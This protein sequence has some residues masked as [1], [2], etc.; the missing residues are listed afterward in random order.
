MIS[1]NGDS[2]SGDSGS[3]AA[4][5]V[6]APDLEELWGL[7][8]RLSRLDGGDLSEGE[9]VEEL[10]A[11]ERLKS[12]LAAAQARVTA[13]LAATRAD[14]EAGLPVAERCRGLGAEVGLARQESPVRG[15]QHLELAL[16]LVRE[17]P[18]TMAALT[19]GEISEWV[20][21]QVARET[22]VL[23]REDR[24]R[25]DAELDGQLVGAGVARI[26]RLARAIGYRLDPGSAVRR[27][28]GATADRR[29]GL[30]PAPDT[31][32]YL[33]GFL[34]V[35]Q[36]VACYAAL[37]KAADA[38]RAVGDARSRGQIMADILVA[39]LTGQ[40]TA[41]GT[42]VAVSMV[43]TDRTLLGG[44]REPG[45][46]DGYGPVPAPVVRDLARD[47]DKVWLRR[48][49]TS[50]TSGELV[51][52]D[53]TSRVFEGQLRRFVITRDQFCR[54]PW[55]DAPIRHVD[56]VT[57]AADG[58]RTSADN[59]EGLCEAC[60]YTKEQPRWLT[61]VLPGPGHAVEITTP[62]GHR[63]HSRAPDPPGHR[64]PVRIDLSYPAVAA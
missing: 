48:L 13:R 46:L 19:R 43:V 56:H 62:T 36:G 30:R 3:G 31:M 57:R 6:P 12:G 39:R 14:S 40:A 59:G 60:N 16:V 55:C 50:P 22:A 20:A 17:L 54:T 37:A 45:H 26:S 7:L 29:V 64:Y 9:M 42:P 49:F 58:G 51:A 63:H 41:Q 33:T 27:V 8:D 5:L 61:R 25:V 28:R 47:A 24:A 10:T 2:G 52:M 4:A 34:P 35:A 18:H 38:E 15:R 44:G 1:G 32:T 53:S 11:M 23:S 21:T